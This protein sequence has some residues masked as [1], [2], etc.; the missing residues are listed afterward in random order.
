VPAWVWW[1]LAAVLVA[2]AVT[3]PLVLAA[4]RR[5]AWG[6][7]MSAASEEAAWFARTLIPQLQQEQSVEQVAGGWRVA[8]DRVAA[9]ED[10]LT[11]LESTAPGESEATRARTLRDAVRSSKDRLDLLVRSEGSTAASAELAAAA[12]AI[13]AA[14]AATSADRPPASS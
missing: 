6:E 13:E 1:L 11:G 10:S 8:R 14:I 12:S 4:R 5:G 9:V 7:A 3:I 2:L